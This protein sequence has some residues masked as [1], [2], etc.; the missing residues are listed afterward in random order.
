MTGNGNFTGGIG[1]EIA[2]GLATPGAFAE[3]FEVDFRR[4]ITGGNV[5]QLMNGS[6]QSVAGGIA[7][8]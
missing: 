2:A 6:T 3:M 1:K 7:V 8:S 5:E 4:S